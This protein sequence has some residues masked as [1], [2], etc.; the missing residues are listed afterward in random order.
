MDINA[1]EKL[2][3]WHWHSE[4]DANPPASGPKAIAQYGH[5]RP[6]NRYAIGQTE[7]KSGAEYVRIDIYQAA[8]AERDAA[9]AALNEARKTDET[10]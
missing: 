3:A 7:Q 5:C 10:I 2:W 8:I 9:L 6:T 4:W 1:P